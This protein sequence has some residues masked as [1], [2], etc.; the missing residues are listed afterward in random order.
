VQKLYLSVLLIALATASCASSAIAAGL[1]SAALK[2]ATAIAPDMTG[3]ETHALKFK[4]GIHKNGSGTDTILHTAVGD[5]NGDGLDDGAIVFYE[6]WGGSG[7]FMRMSVFICKNGKPTQIGSRTLG[8]LSNTKSL[9]INK[10]VLTLDIMTHGPDDSANSPTVH[11]VLNF[12]VKKGK[13]LGP[14]N[15]NM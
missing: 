4:N 11:K 15:I 8:D 14:D 2:N 9:K 10:K 1:T 7:A 5:L 3:G 13:L 6:E 12:Q